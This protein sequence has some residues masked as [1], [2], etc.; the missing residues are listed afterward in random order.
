[1]SLSFINFFD[2]KV[3]S[4]NLTILTFVASSFAL[5]ASYIYFP[6]HFIQKKLIEFPS[7]IF[8]F[9]FQILD[10]NCFNELLI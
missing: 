4:Q 6:W 8:K 7:L 3:K 2:L 1:M 10:F 9:V 5:F